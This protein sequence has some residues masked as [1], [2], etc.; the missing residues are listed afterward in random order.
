[1][2]WYKFKIINKNGTVLL[3]GP[4]KGAH[5]ASAAKKARQ[6]LKVIIEDTDGWR[7]THKIP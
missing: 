7:S 1:M 5:H 4:V 6:Q 3:K 2:P